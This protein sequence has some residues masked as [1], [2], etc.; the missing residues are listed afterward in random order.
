MKN[1]IEWL[2]HATIMIRGEKRIMIDPWKVASPEIVDIVLV[3]HDHFDHCS[4]E[5]IAKVRGPDTVVVGPPDVAAKLG[6]GTIR[7]TAGQQVDIAGVAVAAVP[8]YNLNKQY[9]PRA[10]GWVGYVIT[11]GGERI[12]VAG[13]TDHTPEMDA[14]QADVILLPVGGTYTM[15]ADEAAEAANRIQ[16]RL[17]IPIHYGD[18]V[19]SEEDARRF[20]SRCKV[21]VTV[22]KPGKQI[23][24]VQG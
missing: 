24:A 5:D 4:P 13:D 19:G 14:V 3:T 6:E 9:H 21:P 18:V 7:I 22:L 8:A 20:E 11:M 17:S 10:N 23:G 2:G 16:P 1:A 12:Y 15:T